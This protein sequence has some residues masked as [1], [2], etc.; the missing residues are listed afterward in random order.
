MGY[1]VT[2]DPFTVWHFFSCECITTCGSGCTDLTD[3]VH[4]TDGNAKC[5]T[6]ASL[7]ENVS[8]IVTCSAD[9]STWTATGHD[10]D[11]CTATQ[12]AAISSTPSGDCYLFDKSMLSDDSSGSVNQ[13]SMALLMLSF[14]LSVFA[15]GL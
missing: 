11:N 12:V 9:N 1:H 10:G 3:D 8:S 4:Y 13:V 15:L 2:C 6:M 14:L 7:G 5:I